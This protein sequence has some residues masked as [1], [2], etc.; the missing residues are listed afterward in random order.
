MYLSTTYFCT[1]FTSPWFRIRSS[2]NCYSAET[3][4][5]WSFLTDVTH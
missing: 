3:N 5:C 2:N 4:V 1:Q